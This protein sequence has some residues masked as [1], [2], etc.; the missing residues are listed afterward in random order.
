MFT[1]TLE[2]VSG[3]IVSGVSTD[4]G[5]SLDAAAL[6]E[7]QTVPEMFVFIREALDRRPP[8]IA[9]RYDDEFAFPNLVQVDFNTTR[10]GNDIYISVS[11]FTRLEP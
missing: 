7:H 4:D 2:V 6:A 1:V 9:V 10:S 3:H 11:N 8:A 5:T